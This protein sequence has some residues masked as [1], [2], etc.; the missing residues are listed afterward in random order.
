MSDPRP[1]RRSP[2]RGLTTR[3]RSLVAAGVAAGVCAVVLD[4]RDLLR[5]GLLL[6]AL[7]VLSALLLTLARLELRAQRSVSPAAITAGAGATVVLT[8]TAGSRLPVIGLL[9]TDGVPEVLGEEPRYAVGALPRGTAAAVRYPLA[10]TLRGRHVLGP[11]QVRLADPLGLVEV[12]REL[13]GLTEVLVRPAL[14]AL[15]GLP[16]QLVDSAETGGAPA[17]GGGAPHDL[18]DSL[19]RPYRTGDDLRSV[20]WRSTARRDELMVRPQEQTRRTGTVVLLDVRAAAHHGAGARSTL[21]RAV[22]L[23][24]SA[25][26]HLGREGRTVRLVTSDGFDLGGGGPALDQLALLGT[27]AGASLAGAGEVTGSDE[28]VAV[29]GSLDLAGAEQLVAA[30]TA[31]GPG[32]AVVLGGDSPG[33]ARLRAAGWLVVPAAGDVPLPELWRRLC[34][35]STGA[36][37]RGPLTGVAR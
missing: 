18:Q 5:V 36:S 11:V 37:D 14:V 8:L 35:G 12:R 20:H 26:A 29:L 15:H 7:P 16:G 31:G 10:P 2:L 17:V 23:A 22:S 6:V 30:S 27:V 25:A 33:V 9:M 1:P 3:G 21:E 13:P 32:R 34:S 24:A 28:L 19:V 4:E